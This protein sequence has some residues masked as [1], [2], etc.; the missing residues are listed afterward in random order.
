MEHYR[1]ASSL[2]SDTNSGG[3][4]SG[5]EMYIGA[6]NQGG[7]ANLYTNN[8]IRFAGVLNGLT[9]NEVTDLNDCVTTFHSDLGL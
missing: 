2:G 6:R 5:Y 3:S 4:R 7:S 1:N 8:T 9:D